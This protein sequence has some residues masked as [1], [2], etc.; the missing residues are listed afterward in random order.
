MPKTSSLR[1]ALLALLA[2]PTLSGCFP[3]AK[4]DFLKDDPAAGKARLPYRLLKVE[5]K[6]ARKG[7]GSKA[8]DFS[9]SVRSGEAAPP[10]TEERRAMLG[11]LAS[12]CFAGGPEVSAVVEVM[13]GR[14]TF[15]RG[16]LRRTEAVEAGVRLTLLD[17]AGDSK[18]WAEG[19]AEYRVRSMVAS[20]DYLD[21]LYDKALRASLRKAAETLD[22]PGQ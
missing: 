17:A 2:V 14:Q 5:V 6:D 1:L 15:S 13:E 18:G 20:Q 4:R 7:S 3:A 9:S 12:A 22:Q 11:E 19:A 21:K 16:L 8:L 10:L